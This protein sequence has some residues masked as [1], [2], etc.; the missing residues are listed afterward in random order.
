MSYSVSSYAVLDE[1][2]AAAVGRVGAVSCG[3][4][5]SPYHFTTKWIV[6][7]ASSSVL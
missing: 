7:V 6:S 5:I 2:T 1:K 4:S 3:T